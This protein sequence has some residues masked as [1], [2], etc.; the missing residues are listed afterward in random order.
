M[1]NYLLAAL[2]FL[3]PT[4]GWA[5]G[6][7]NTVPPMCTAETLLTTCV[8]QV[9]GTV[10]RI[11]DATN[12]TVCTN[13]GAG[14]TNVTCQFN[15]SAWGP[16]ATIG[17]TG[18][19]WT[20]ANGET[21]FNSPDSTFTFQ[22]SGNVGVILK[23]ADSS[24]P[25]NLTLDATTTGTITVGSSD[26]ASVSLVVDDIIVEIG[27]NNPQTVSLE[28][29][30]TGTVILDFRDYGDTTDD[31]M[32][33]VLFSGNCT[34]ATTGAE[35]CDL[36]ISTTEAGANEIR[37]VVDGDGDIDLSGGDVKL[38]IEESGTFG[39]PNTMTATSSVLNQYVGIPRLNA[40]HIAVMTNGTTS[41]AVANPLL[42]NCNAIVN[43]AEADDATNYITGASSYKYTWAADVALND[44]I[45]CVIAYPA[46]TAPISLG[47]WFRTATA[48]SSGDIDI[49][50]D[51]G[52]VTDGTISTFA[53]SV[54]NEWHW[55]ELDITTACAAECSAVDGIEFL[56]TAQGAGAAV[57]DDIVMNID[58]IAMWKAADE[59]VIGDIQV[60]GLIDF[61]YAPTAAGSANTMTEGVEWTSHFINYQTGAD[62][63]ISITDLS[64]QYGTTLEALND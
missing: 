24:A 16:M 48:I 39:A 13:S 34:T 27:T 30:S 5:Q 25:A 35:D 10:A 41:T 61:A 51:D 14:T 20:G 28:N 55:V 59:K 47:F 42:A 54:L 11:T 37:I 3:V 33:H 29:D 18:G 1:R 8:P 62:A 43:G 44:G 38:G 4:V 36:T 60:G 57:L 53:T 7:T 52:G 22:N 17:A 58:Q 63:I 2:L 56:A 45:D 32:A 19:V 49:N 23:A 15:G 21:M 64:G 26:V 40:T 46:V 9:Q 6:N 12:A 50:F 31:D